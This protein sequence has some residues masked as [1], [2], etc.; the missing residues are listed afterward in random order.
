MFLLLLL[1]L[2]LYN[3]STRIR[4]FPVILLKGLLFWSLIF[5]PQFYPY[6]L[7]II[8]HIEIFFHLHVSQIQSV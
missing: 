6:M 5:F 1:L 4:C 3:I 2:L 7:I 8:L